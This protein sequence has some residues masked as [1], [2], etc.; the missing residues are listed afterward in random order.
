M[1][2]QVDGDV[3]LAAKLFRG[4]ADPTRLAILR[5]LMQGERCVTDL[6]RAVGGSQSNVSTHLA[7]LKDCGLVADRP[8]GRLVFYRIAIPEVLD[9]LQAAERL[10][11]ITG[12]AVELCPNYQGSSGNVSPALGRAAMAG[13]SS[14]NGT[15]EAIG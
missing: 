9:V 4:F 2:Q 8:E 1:T 3:A 15:G 6:V 12:T 13:S 7:C 11:A 5:Q 10:L 14:G